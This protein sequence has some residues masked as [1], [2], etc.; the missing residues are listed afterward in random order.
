[1]EPEQEIKGLVT[2]DEPGLAVPAH[3]NVPFDIKTGPMNMYLLTRDK[4]EVLQA[5]DDS[6]ESTMFGISIGVFL[7]TTSILIPLYISGAP[8]TLLIPFLWMMLFGFGALSFYFGKKWRKCR[9]KRKEQ[10]EEIIEKYGTV[11]SLTPQQK[12]GQP[13]P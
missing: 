7:T 2:R 12:T 11:V 8:H 13:S 6:D 3:I 1:M 10:F 9:K 5:G 4:L